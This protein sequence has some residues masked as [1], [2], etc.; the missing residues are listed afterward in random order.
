M[1]IRN[2]FFLAILAVFTL[3]ACNN[4]DFDLS[5]DNGEQGYLVLTLETPSNLR[6]EAGLNTRDDSGT[7]KENEIKS[8]RVV[9]TNN[10]GKVSFVSNPKVTNGVTEEFKVPFGKHYVYAIINSPIEIT[11]G[12]D[13]QRVITVA[14]E[15]DAISG[16]KGGSFLMINQRNND[17]EAGIQTEI[18]A[19]NTAA[20]PAKATIF[21]DRVACKITDKTAGVTVNLS[22]T[23]NG[24][25]DEVDV[26][27]F[28]ILNVNKQF[29]LLQ[30]W[31]TVN[32]G[33]ETLVTNVFETPTPS[34]NILANQ[35]Y[36]NI[37]QYTKLTKEDG[38]ITEI[39]DLTLGKTDLF[40]KGP[41]YTT[42]NRPIITLFGEN[43]TAGRGEA[44]GVIYKVQAKKGGNNIGTFYKYKSVLYNDFA[45]IQ[46][47]P[48]FEGTTLPSSDNGKLRAMGINVYEN[49]IMYYTYF[50]RDKNAA[51]QYKG[52]NYYGVFRNSSYKLTINMISALGDDVPGGGSVDPD[53]PG[54]PGNPPIDTDEAYLHVSVTVNPWVLNTIELQF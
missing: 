14:A 51:H 23:T 21:V 44:T 36:F 48:E 9:L 33:G 4:D 39:T 3:L 24:F 40:G 47:L 7:D 34:S 31:S 2:S 16:Y 1:K 43:L 35:Y 30:K 5:P 18:D 54:E 26:E 45:N 41:V 32:P 6:T 11:E 52:E 22:G 46:A 17:S 29:N 49:G 19:N 15:A 42:E 37:G 27:G 10:S 13:L 8:L 50:V 25:I 38:I 20:N 28:V 12:E 53:E